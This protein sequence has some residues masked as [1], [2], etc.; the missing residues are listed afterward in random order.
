M[1]EFN[2]QKM[3]NHMRSILLNLLLLV[4]SL[5]FA[6]KQYLCNIA[7]DE[8]PNSKVLLA[9]FYGDKNSIIDTAFTNEKGEATFTFNDDNYSGLYRVYF[10]NQKKFFDFIFNKEEITLETEF[11]FPMD[12]VNVIKSLENTI[13]YNFLRTDREYKLKFELL[14]PVIAYYPK[15][16][17]F[18][19]IAADKYEETQKARNDYIR[20]IK[21]DNPNSFAAD[22]A[23][24]QLKPIIP[25]T[26]NEREMH[27]YLLTH[28]FD[29]ID[30]NNPYLLRSDV[31]PNK[32]LEYLTL[33]SNSNY[34]QSELEDAFIK[35]IDILF[36]KPFEDDLVK[37]Y[38]IN[39]LLKGF[40]SYGFEKVIVH[41]ADTYDEETACE[42]EE[43]KS[44]LQTR[45]DNFKKLAV[46][47]IAP[48]FII[49]TADGKTISFSD[50]DSEYI[51]LIFWATWCPHCT[52]SIPQI[53]RMYQKQKQKKV[54]VIAFSLDTDETAWR[55]YINENK[56]TWI[57]ASDLKSWKSKITIDYNIYATPTIILLD[58]NR[59]IISKP[60]S[61][62]QIE[63]EFN[64]Q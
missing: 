15:T 39:Y 49:P 11:D 9:D 24:F 55:N 29:E 61:L 10:G 32:I 38:V 6:Q 28:F 40:E 1:Q 59:K 23:L 37:D 14:T 36:S 56:L 52:Q 19:D 27:Q 25:S 43:R 2:L 42:D 60:L 8:Y 12:S 58:K 62:S 21:E 54:E 35:A 22:L 7:I 5:S 53:S 34:S 17:K 13:Y 31:Y 20:K 16:D 18:Y 30:F 3:S 26:L 4:S 50:I 46:G 51:M 57:N 33:Y 41:I 47:Q 63:Q 64:R 44:D 45:L 48:D